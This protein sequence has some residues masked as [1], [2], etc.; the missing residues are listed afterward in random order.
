M[1]VRL[2]SDVPLDD[3][4][5]RMEDTTASTKTASVTS[6][7]FSSFS[8]SIRLHTTALCSVFSR[9]SIL[10]GLPLKAEGMDLAVGGLVAQW[11]GHRIRDREVAGS[12]ADRVVIK[13]QCWTSCSHPLSPSSIILYRPKGGDALQLGR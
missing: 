9:K 8:T 5:T 7:L 10:T 3:A 4:S 12:T 11:L 2:R 6:S 1:N 13:L